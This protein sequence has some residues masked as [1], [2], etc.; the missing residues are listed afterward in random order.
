MFWCWCVFI[1]CA[2]KHYGFPYWWPGKRVWNKWN[3]FHFL[4]FSFINDLSYRVSCYGC[5]LLMSSSS[6]CF[7]FFLFFIYFLK[8]HYYRFGEMR[9]YNLWPFWL[10]VPK[11]TTTTETH[12]RN[13]T[14]KRTTRFPTIVYI[15]SIQKQIFASRICHTYSIIRASFHF[16]VTQS[17]KVT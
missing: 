2:L 13:V 4:I 16:S 6:L 7:I 15:L 10:T 3:V 1:F 8:P 5:V 17:A 14:Y 9:L 11:K 12:Q